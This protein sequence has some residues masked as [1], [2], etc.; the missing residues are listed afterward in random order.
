MRV[1]A[2]TK[3]GEDRCYLGSR[4]GL[5]IGNEPSHRRKEARAGSRAG[6]PKKLPTVLP[7]LQVSGSHLGTSQKPGAFPLQA[8]SAITCPS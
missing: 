5:T 8:S 1:A 6:V 7:S 2:M 3:L 4:L